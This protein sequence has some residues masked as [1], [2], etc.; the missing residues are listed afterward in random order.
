[1]T[2]G[3]IP[4]APP[5]AASSS[6]SNAFQLTPDHFVQAWFLFLAVLVVVAIAFHIINTRYEIKLRRQG[7]GSLPDMTFAI[8]VAASFVSTAVVL[9]AL[10][11]LTLGRS[12]LLKDFDAFWKVGTPLLALGYFLYQLVAGAMFAT[13]SVSLSAARD[14]THPTRLLVKLSIE[15][16]AQWMADIASAAVA[17]HPSDHLWTPLPKWEPVQLPGRENE[18]LRLA[19][20]EKTAT[21]F[22]MAGVSPRVF[23]L[24]V[25]VISYASYWPVPSESFARVRIS[26][27]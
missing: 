26:Q 9:I 1:M 21:E 7:Q 27:A 18:P 17:Q 23:Y 11:T 15:R 19:P 16:G 5:M 20:G 13:T 12:D 14:P 2:K 4:N 22:S 25:R 3:I 24:T 8:L 6:P 10:A